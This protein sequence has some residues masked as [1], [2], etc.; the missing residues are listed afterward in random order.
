MATNLFSEPRKLFLKSF[1]VNG[2]QI[3]AGIWVLVGFVGKFEWQN[4]RFKLGPV[5]DVFAQPDN[6]GNSRRKIARALFPCRDIE[7]EQTT[8][9]CRS[10]T[11]NPFPLTTRVLVFSGFW[12]LP[13]NDPGCGSFPAA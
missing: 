13:P 10:K 8:L 7:V 11:D 1:F 2:V 4:K 6:D 3:K 9:S 12:P 5:R